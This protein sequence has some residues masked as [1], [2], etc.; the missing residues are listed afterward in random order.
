MENLHW[1]LGVPPPTIYLVKFNFFYIL[2][3]SSGYFYNISRVSLNLC[4]AFY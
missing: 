1:I 3:F 2:L 4:F